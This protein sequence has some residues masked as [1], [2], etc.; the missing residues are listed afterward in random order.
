VGVFFLITAALLILSHFFTGKKGYK[1]LG[2]KEGLI[3]GIAQGI[4]VLPGISRSGI[5]ITASL[6]VGIEREQAGEYAFLI[7]IPAI[8]GALI[9]KIK[10]IEVLSI[11]P[12]VLLAG[13]ATSFV[14]GLF[15][16]LFL[17]RLIRK[18][19]LFFFSFYLIPAGIISIFF[20]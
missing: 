4:G 5:S 12:I 3:T 9:L 19:R 6:F 8:I 10:D 2:I 14:V 7:S 13:M 18:G 15:S 11:D 20:I 1:D 16:L 17:I